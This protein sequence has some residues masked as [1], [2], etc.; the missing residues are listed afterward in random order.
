[1][2][3]GSGGCGSSG[4]SGGEGSC[5]GGGNGGDDQLCDTHARA[6]TKQIY[7]RIYIVN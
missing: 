1:M 2:C 4:Y 6:R 7:T 3:D 5:T